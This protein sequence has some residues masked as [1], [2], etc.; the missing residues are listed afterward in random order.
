MVQYMR[1]ELTVYTAQ[2]KRDTGVHRSAAYTTVGVAPRE[3]DG[4][5]DR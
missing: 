1:S 4:A 2:A 3:C 5:G